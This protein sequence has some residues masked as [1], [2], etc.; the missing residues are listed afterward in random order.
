MCCFQRSE[1]NYTLRKNSF[2]LF[3]KISNQKWRV[4]YGLEGMEFILIITEKKPRVDRKNC[5]KVLAAKS[6]RRTTPIIFKY[7]YNIENH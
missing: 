2:V 5:D 4:S 3:I 6:K 7:K 1:F